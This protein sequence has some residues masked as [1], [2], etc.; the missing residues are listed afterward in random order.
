M[1]DDPILIEAQ[2]R[3]AAAEAEAA[4]WMEFIA[5]YMELKGSV[6]PRPVS[7]RQLPSA[8]ASRNYSPNAIPP[9]WALAG[10]HSVENRGR[11]AETEEAARAIIVELGRPVPTREMLEQLEA[12]GVIVGGQ[13]PSAT[14]SARL[15]RAPSIIGERGSGWR[16]REA[17]RRK[18]ETVAPP[19]TE[20]ATVSSETPNDADRRGEVE[21]DNIGN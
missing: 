2:A 12:R 21:H 19:S 16:L 11:I 20:E 13:D 6:S 10:S 4:R 5:R 14:L 15:S 8:T 9:G 1:N 17:I 3:I 7:G 18:D